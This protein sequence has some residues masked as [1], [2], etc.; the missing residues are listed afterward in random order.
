[1]LGKECQLICFSPRESDS[2]K[3]PKMSSGERIV[4]LHPILDRQPVIKTF[5]P[6]NASLIS[7]DPPSSPLHL[8]YFPL[9]S[10]WVLRQILCVQSQK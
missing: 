9:G 5:L 7:S 1:M 2:G 10:P 8:L 4:R 6:V 3:N